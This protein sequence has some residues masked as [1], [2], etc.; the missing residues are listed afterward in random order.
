MESAGC[1]AE[2]MLQL[3]LSFA[4]AR[5][6]KSKGCGWASTVFVPVSLDSHVS[7]R[8]GFVQAGRKQY[9]QALQLFL[10]ALTAPTMV[11]SAIT[12]AIFKK[13]MLVSLIHHGRHLLW[14]L[15]TRST[16][17]QN[18]HAIPTGSVVTLHQAQCLFRCVYHRALPYIVSQCACVPFGSI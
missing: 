14:S 5:S 7:N 3:V 10:N 4:L 12:M 18:A 2:L 15:H 11:V 9:A 13:F 17:Q 1:F 16:V 8:C 6:Q